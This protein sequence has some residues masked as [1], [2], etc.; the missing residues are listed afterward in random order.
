[1]LSRRRGKRRRS[2]E[3][4]FLSSTHLNSPP[5]PP[6][7]RTTTSDE[8]GDH[9]GRGHHVTSKRSP[10]SSLPVGPRQGPPG[11]GAAPERPEQEMLGGPHKIA[12]TSS[13]AP[14]ATGAMTSQSCP[15]RYVPGLGAT[16]SCS[17]FNGWAESHIV[18]TA[19]ACPRPRYL[20]GNHV[21]QLSTSPPLRTHCSR[22]GSHGRVGRSG[23]ASV[24]GGSTRSAS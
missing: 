24:R 22:I 8:T 18:A 1:M 19:V 23:R 17:T 5:S 9:P 14:S 20:D 6:C 11:R 15:R 2:K 4:A 13:T 7:L 21:D 12:A 10:S 16:A 3:R